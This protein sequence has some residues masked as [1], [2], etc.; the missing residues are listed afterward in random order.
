LPISPFVIAGFLL[1]NSLALL[2][3]PMSGVK[4]DIRFTERHVRFDAV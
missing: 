4:E 1:T 2:V 3:L